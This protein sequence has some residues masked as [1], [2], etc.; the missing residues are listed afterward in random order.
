MKCPV[1]GAKTSRLLWFD[2][3]RAFFQCLEHSNHLIFPIEVFILPEELLY[4][5]V[6]ERTKR[7]SEVSTIFVNPEEAKTIA[8]MGSRVD[9]PAVM[10]IISNITK[11]DM[12]AL[13][14]KYAEITRIISEEI[15]YKDLER[16]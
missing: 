10:D 14:K 9:S 8:A 7:I 11:E 1:C 6:F 4:E 13:Y 15:R 2:G 16:S 5:A 12:E 3:S